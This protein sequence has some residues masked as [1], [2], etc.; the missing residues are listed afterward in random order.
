MSERKPHPISA[1]IHLYMIYPIRGTYNDE[2]GIT[3]YSELSDILGKRD[4]YCFLLTNLVH[5]RA[6]DMLLT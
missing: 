4:A 2:G 6:V 5:Y 3:L 1:S